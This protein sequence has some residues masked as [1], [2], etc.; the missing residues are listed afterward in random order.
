[1]FVRLHERAGAGGEVRRVVAVCDESLLGKRFESEGR[2]LDL[3]VH[4]AFYEG[5]R[6][7]A[8][9]VVELLKN[10]ASVNAVGA[11][12]VECVAKVFGGAGFDIGGVPVLQVYRV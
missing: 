3:S 10:C 2:V 4:R 1:M 5:E 8:T 6:A 11:E 12:S 7:D 9:K